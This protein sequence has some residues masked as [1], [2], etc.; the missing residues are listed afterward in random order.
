[1]LACGFGGKGQGCRQHEVVGDKAANRDFG[2]DIEKYA[3][4]AECKARLPDDQS[5]AARS[6]SAM[7]R[8][9]S[10]EA[11]PCRASRSVPSKIL[12]S[13]KKPVVSG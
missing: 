4:G 2:A 11:H 3:N 8:G 7:N 9:R 1:M 5:A 6:G 13:P 10:S 12:V